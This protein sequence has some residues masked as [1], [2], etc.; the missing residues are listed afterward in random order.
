L[1]HIDLRLHGI[2]TG[3]R[4]LEDT[5]LES[6]VPNPKALPVPAQQLQPITSPVDKCLNITD[7]GE[8]IKGDLDW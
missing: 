4:P 1:S 8:Q 6:L 3:D 2:P 7:F 5:R